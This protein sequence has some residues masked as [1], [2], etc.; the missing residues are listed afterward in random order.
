MKPLELAGMRFGRLAA[1][2]VAP[3]DDGA[4]WWRCACDCG[5]ETTARGA[6]LRRGFVSS[7]GCWR[8]EM[9]KTRR[10]H[11]KSN[12]RIY[13]IWQAMRDRTQNPRASRYSYYGGRGIKV[14]PEWE[15]FSVFF[16]WANSNG[17]LHSLSIDRID[18]DGDYEPK[19]CR[20]A[21]QSQQVRNRRKSPANSK[22]IPK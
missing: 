17:Y 2:E 1:I 4:R 8:R 13:R 11:G 15:E 10:T 5:R 22:E 16:E 3:S 12:S 18:N 21:T 19:N 20:W 9:P 6:D 7:C 14:C